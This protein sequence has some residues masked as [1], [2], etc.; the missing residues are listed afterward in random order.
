M[1]GKKRWIPYVLLFPTIAV[2]IG[3]YGYPIIKVFLLSLQNYN[4]ADFSNKG[5]IGLE[6]FKQIFFND[7]NV[8]VAAVFS[9]KWVVSQVVL[10][11]VF[12]MIMALILNAKF[13]GRGLVRSLSLI[14]WAVS[15][16]LATMLWSLIL[17]QSIGL[18][19]LI[20]IKFGVSPGNVPSWLG[21]PKLVFTSV[22]ICELWKGIP[23]FAITLLAAMQGIPDDIYEACDI[24]GQGKYRNLDI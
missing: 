14:P 10:Q 2:I 20:L 7:K 21:N 13:K 22:T 15:G 12:G 3:I 11:L 16:V 4:Y 5:Y 17:N 23:F 1:K 8:R 9:V 18:V 24:D 19:N 6:N